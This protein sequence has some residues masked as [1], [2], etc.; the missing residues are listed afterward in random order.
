MYQRSYP[1]PQQHHDG[2]R[3]YSNNNNHLIHNLKEEVYNILNG[4]DLRD[5]AIDIVKLVLTDKHGICIEHHTEIER[6]VNNKLRNRECRVN[7]QY[8]Q[9]WTFP[10]QFEVMSHLRKLTDNCNRIPNIQ[11]T[12]N[13]LNSILENNLKPQ[14][15]NKRSSVSILEPNSNL[16]Q[17]HRKRTIVEEEPEGVGTSN[18]NEKKRE[19]RSLVAQ[20]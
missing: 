2:S 13:K 12:V 20:Y 6:L 4:A 5:Y 15:E 17:R 19:K 11:R 18:D 3:M 1:Y 10:Q 16:S 9:D 14:D 7:L 8:R